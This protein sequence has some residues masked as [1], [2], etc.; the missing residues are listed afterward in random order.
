MPVEIH[1]QGEDTEDALLEVETMFEDEFVFEREP[2]ESKVM[3]V[4]DFVN[5]GETAKCKP[6]EL[7]DDIEIF[8]QL[9]DQ[10]IKFI[11]SF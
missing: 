10:F 7:A 4:K 8:G 5:N 11:Q 2:P 1:D 6:R 3:Y 9:Q